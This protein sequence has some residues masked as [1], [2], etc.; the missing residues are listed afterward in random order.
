MKILIVD[1]NLDLA[2]LFV[3]IL[4]DEGFEAFNFFGSEFE[5]HK[6]IKE[7]QPAWVLLDIHLLNV[8]GITIAQQISRSKSSRGV[9]LALMSGDLSNVPP[10]I[11]SAT[12]VELVIQKP[13]S[14]VEIVKALRSEPYKSRKIE[15]KKKQAA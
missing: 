14:Y 8:S 15:I 1:D 7:I 2:D 6:K 11:E 3:E 5:I 13:F 9:R 12:G 10:S 4:T